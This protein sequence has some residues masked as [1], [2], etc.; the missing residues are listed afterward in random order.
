MNM[1][2]A[3]FQLKVSRMLHD[4]HETVRAVLASLEALLAKQS[5]SELPDISRSSVSGLLGRVAELADGGLERH[6]GFEEDELF[7]LLVKAGGGDM[8]DV[9]IGEHEILLPMVKQVAALAREG[10]EGRFTA[11]SWREFHQLGLEFGERLDSHIHKEEAG[12]LPAVEDF[13]DA[14]TDA[15]LAAAYAENGY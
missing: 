11:A 13:V 7:P 8:C 2:G 9:L 15:R 4:E 12:L 1:T 6:F 5:P 14:A 10:L 3:E